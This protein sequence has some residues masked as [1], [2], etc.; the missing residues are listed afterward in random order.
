[1]PLNDKD[2]KTITDFRSA[3]E[4]GRAG[5]ERYGPVSRDDRPDESVLSSR[6][7]VMD[8]LWLDLTVRP[9]IPQIRVGI[10]TDDRWKNEELEERIEETGDTMPEF[11]ELGFDEAGLDWREPPVEHFRDQGKYFCFATP[12]EIASIAD[13]A[14]PELIERVQR[15]FEGYYQAFGAAIARLKAE[16]AN[17]K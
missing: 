4:R 13:L 2:R 15:M 3:F 5:D 1:M 7:S 8:Q 14:K 11:L 12:L 6:F 9:F 10:V 17:S 16:A